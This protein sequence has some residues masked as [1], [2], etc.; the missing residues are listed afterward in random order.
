MATWCADKVKSLMLSAFRS[1]MALLTVTGGQ[2]P[3][4]EALMQAHMDEDRTLAAHLDDERKTKKKKAKELQSLQAQVL[5][6]EDGH[7]GDGVVEAQDES[8]RVM[9]RSLKEAVVHLSIN[10]S[11]PLPPRQVVGLVRSTWPASCGR[12]ALKCRFASSETRQ[13][14]VGGWNATRAAAG[15]RGGR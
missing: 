14:G 12:G 6:E 8:E 3:T 11:G 2:L 4:M 5:G 1:H 15:E 10:F 13:R 7:L 9:L